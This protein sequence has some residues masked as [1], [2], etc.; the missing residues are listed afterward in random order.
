MFFFFKLELN[1][2]LVSF[3]ITDICQVN[4]QVEE[5]GKLDHVD[6]SKQMNGHST[7]PKPDEMKPSSD[8][9][10]LICLDEA[11]AAAEQLD[12]FTLDDLNDEV[13]RILSYPGLV[14]KVLYA[15]CKVTVRC[16]NAH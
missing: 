3:Q 11:E 12:G 14:H 5:N 9:N 15:F 1:C 8:P 2:S 10:A 13:I 4:S 16:I 7:S 6:D